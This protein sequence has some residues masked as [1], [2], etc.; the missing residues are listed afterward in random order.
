MRA[1]GRVFTSYQ[2]QIQE[3]IMGLG[4]GYHRDLQLTK[5]PFLYGIHLVKDTLQ[6]LLEVTPSIRVH[7]EKLAVAMSKELYAT[8]EVYKQ[9][10]AG[11]PFREAYLKVKEELFKTE[12]NKQGAKL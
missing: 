11:V 2:F 7:K 12:E 6:L 3:I 1:N 8:D 10:V 4:S 5:K 9:V